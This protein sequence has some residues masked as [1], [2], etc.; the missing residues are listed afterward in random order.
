MS[1]KSLPE[2]PVEVLLRWEHFGGTW[3]VTSRSGSRITVSLCRCDSGEE[4]DRVISDDPALA[5]WLSAR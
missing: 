4:V 1:S 2:G 3:R 5:A